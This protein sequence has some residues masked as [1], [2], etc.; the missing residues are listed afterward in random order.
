MTQTEDATI[1]LASSIAVHRA[2]SRAETKGG[3]LERLGWLDVIRGIAVASTALMHLLEESS[4]TASWLGREILSPGIYGIVLFFL[5]SGFVIPLTLE[6]RGSLGA[7][8]VARVFRLYPL[9]WFSLFLLMLLVALRIATLDSEFSSSLPGAFWWNITMVQSWVGQPDA[10]GLYWTLGFELAFYAASALLFDMRLLE[11][12][13]WIVTLGTAYILVRGVVLPLTGG[14]Y[15]Y[16]PAEFW[17]LTFPVGTLWYRAWSR[18]MSW[19]RAAVIT[20]L[21]AATILTSYLVTW[22]FSG[23]SQQ[24]PPGYNPRSWIVPYSSLGASGLAYATFIALVVTGAGTR[25]RFLKWLGRISYSVYLMH[26]VLLRIPLPVSRSFE[27][28][29]RLAVILP[30]S[31]LTYRFI[32]APSIAWGRSVTRRLGFSRPKY[33]ANIAAMATASAPIDSTATSNIAA[34]SPP[35]VEKAAPVPQVTAPSNSGRLTGI[36]AAAVIAGTGG[37]FAHEPH[38]AGVTFVNFDAESTPKEVLGSGW[39]GFEQLDTG[40][41]F[42]WC[43]AKACSLNLDA[44]RTEQF[45]RLRV[46]PYTHPNSPSQTLRLKVNGTQVGSQTLTGGPTVYRFKVPANTWREGRNEIKFEFAYAEAPKVYF[47]TSTDDRKLAA[48]FDWVD[49]VPA[50]PVSK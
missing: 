22:V 27:F 6:R 37:Y 14:A 5:V 20:G 49:V 16:F 17:A 31:A 33:Q 19:T 46:Y 35:T 28:V 39:S 32:E 38:A 18:S 48:A 3:E 34:S 7:F 25:L 30:L 9:Y 11:K 8:A 4:D 43:A 13:G 1:G 50:A 26:G 24:A 44:T 41:S 12:T 10:I 29:I 15:H 40:D 2:A 21:L 36:L 47:S 45:V 23:Y 42:S